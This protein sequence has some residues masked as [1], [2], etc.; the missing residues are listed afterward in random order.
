[1]RYMRCEFTP[2]LKFAT[3]NEI[4]EV[5]LIFRQKKT[6]QNTYIQLTP[7]SVKLTIV[8]GNLSLFRV[9]LI[10]MVLYSH[11]KHSANEGSYISTSF[12]P[13]RVCAL[14]LGVAG[15]A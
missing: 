15:G 10:C 4:P 12:G 1:M 11:S 9:H 7:E 8:S 5:I 3:L 13:S 14:P 6:Q 2:I